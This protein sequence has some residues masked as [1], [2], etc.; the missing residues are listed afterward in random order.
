MYM[1]RKNENVTG[2]AAKKGKGK[3]KGKD[4]KSINYSTHCKITGHDASECRKLKKEQEAKCQG[5]EG[6]WCTMVLWGWKS[7]S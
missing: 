1:E 2:L 7:S 5:S 4:D 3:G 6:P